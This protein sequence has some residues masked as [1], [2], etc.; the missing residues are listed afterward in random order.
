MAIKARP[1]LIL[2]FL[3]IAMFFY[4]IGS[5]TGFLVLFVTGGVCELLFWANL[6]KQKK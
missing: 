2:L 6:F 4:A 1:V 3:L 5:A